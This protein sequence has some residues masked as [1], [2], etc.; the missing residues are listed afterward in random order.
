VRKSRTL[1]LTCARGR[2]GACCA[3]AA[4]AGREV[5][6]AKRSAAGNA[7]SV[8]AKA[9]RSR[10]RTVW[11]WFGMDPQAKARRCVEQQI[12]TFCLR[13]CIL[14]GSIRHSQR[15]A[16]LQAGICIVPP[17]F[18]KREETVTQPALH[19]WPASNQ[20][21]GAIRPQ[22]EPRKEVPWQT[23]PRWNRSTQ[24]LAKY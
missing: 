19:A 7:G 21:A 14:A 16:A 4:A 10:R 13:A 22:V 9:S 5:R 20:S 12:K 6:C 8:T 11:R 3:G 15:K 18:G 17:R 23:R 1:I 2:T 24:R